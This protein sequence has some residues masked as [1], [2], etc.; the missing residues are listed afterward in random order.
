M[1]YCALI[2]PS[3][4]RKKFFIQKGKNVN[5]NGAEFPQS[6]PGDAITLYCLW[7]PTGG[8]PVKTRAG[9]QEAGSLALLASF[10]HLWHFLLFFF[11]AFGHFWPLFGW[12]WSLL[13]IFLLP[14]LTTMRLIWPPVFFLPA[15]AHSAEA[16]CQKWQKWPKGAQKWLKA[17]AAA[18]KWT[19]WAK[20]AKSCLKLA[21]SWKNV[22]VEAPKIG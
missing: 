12:F 17:S 19:K 1:H 8:Q 18:W 16:K 3:G 22:A 4:V 9:L 7:L 6:L 21:K 14:F 5:R 2:F 15:F 11:N 13:T 20:R 10:G